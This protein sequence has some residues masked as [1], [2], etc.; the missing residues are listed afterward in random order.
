MYQLYIKMRIRIFIL[1][2]LLPLMA[3]SQDSLPNEFTYEVNRVLPYISISKDSLKKAETL[4]DLD[5]NYKETWVRNYI[6][7]EI[8]AS[9]NGKIENAISENNVLSQEQKDLM[10]G[11]DSNTDIKVIVHYIPENNL[12]HNE[13]KLNDFTFS[14]NPDFPAEYPDG[15]EKMLDYLKENAIDKIPV[16][17][18]KDYDFAAVKFTVSEEGE[19]KNVHLFDMSPFGILEKKEIDSLLLETIRTMPCWKPAEYADGLKVAQDYV[20]SV[21]NH[22]NCVIPLLSIREY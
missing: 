16:D 11:A 14:I 21:G 8:L 3:V 13:A 19:L 12:I 2:L 17:S 18:F 6:S 5:R 10:L 4:I 22:K 20:F 9:Q 15:N 7:V 1:L